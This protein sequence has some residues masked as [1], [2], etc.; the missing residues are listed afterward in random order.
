M[1]DSTYEAV[2]M[3]RRRANKLD[4]YTPSDF[5]LQRDLTTEQFLDSVVWERAWELCS[6]PN[7]RWFDII[8]LDLKDKLQENKYPFD[9]PYEVP[10]KYLQDNW[11]F[12]KIPE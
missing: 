3:I 8:R 10:A 2:N 4:P 12:Y 5:D 11:Y 9:M 6:E 1:D 7:G